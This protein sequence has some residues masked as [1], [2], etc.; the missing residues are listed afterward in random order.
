MAEARWIEGGQREWNVDI[1]L[2]FYSLPIKFIKWV[3]NQQKIVLRFK[4]Q[5]DFFLW[6]LCA[7]D[8]EVRSST[9]GLIICDLKFF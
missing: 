4:T 8:P 2:L 6:N 3:E 7:G 5:N 1:K 9:L